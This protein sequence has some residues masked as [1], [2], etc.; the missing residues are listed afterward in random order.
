M[1]ATE[2]NKFEELMVQQR[3]TAALDLAMGMQ[4][5][6]SRSAAWRLAAGRAHLALGNIGSAREQLEQAER[7]SPGDE[8]IDLHLAIV[9]YRSARSE[10]AIERLV[11]LIARNP[12]CKVDATI[13]L[14]EVLHRTGR[15]SE[16]EA[17]ISK[18]GEWMNDPRARLFVARA[19]ERSDPPKT[20]EAL[21]AMAKGN[22]PAHLRRIAGFEA[23]R[24]LDAA[25]RYREAFE[26]ATFLHASTGAPYDIG[27][28][29]H[30]IERQ[31]SMTIGRGAAVAGAPRVEGTA[32]IIA[33]P[34]SG[35][36]L[37]EQMLDRHPA[38]SG[39]GE[40]EGVHRMHASAIDGGFDALDPT[41]I[42]AGSLARWQR[43]YLA[44]AHHLKSPSANW[45]LDK[46]LI[47]W[48]HLPLVNSVLPGCVFIAIDRDPRDMA[49]S[50]LLGNFHPK[51]FG[52][53]ASLE[54]IRRVATLHRSILPQMLQRLGCAHHAVVY[55]DLVANPRRATEAMLAL[56]GLP[57]D[58]GPLAPEANTRTVLTLSFEQVRRPINAR[59]IGRWRNYEWAFGSEWDSLG[60]Q[61]D[62]RLAA[63][64]S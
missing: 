45:T 3:F 63:T 17:L 22:D 36:T 47:A 15:K 21:L 1:A 52:W 54:S 19:G 27:E 37:I 48:R 2:S 6:D 7:R 18:G 49:I 8:R 43:D 35:T 61:H 32:M 10:R 20:I 14:A 5:V 4:R 33:L 9:E 55:E 42:P 44:G 39:I 34:R 46:N 40:F 50:T 57:M 30:S 64:Q 28:L 41:A 25:G 53:T 59:S 58:E 38:I 16:L 60:S 56:L 26:L 13:V 24:L 29:E 23:V 12:R 11:R 51:T 62:A 31:R